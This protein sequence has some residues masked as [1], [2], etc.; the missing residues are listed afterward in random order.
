[1][2]RKTI[3]ILLSLL[4]IAA[5]CAELSGCSRIENEEEAPVDSPTVD[6][7]ELGEAMLSAAGDTPAMTNVDSSNERA[8]D[9][10]INISDLDYAKVDGYFLSYAA[11]GSGYELAV[12]AVRDAVDVKAKQKSSI[13]RS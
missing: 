10:F 4:L 11:D 3:I 5:S 1:M 9:L 8:E 7:R 12:I 6:M 13:R 2:I